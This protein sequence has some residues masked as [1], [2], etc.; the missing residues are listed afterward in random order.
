MSDIRCALRFM[1]VLLGSVL[2]AIPSAPLLSAQIAAAPSDPAQANSVTIDVNVADNLG[3]AVR[4]LTEQ[5]FTVLD[6][7][8]PAKVTG[9]RAVDTSKEPDAVR[10]LLVVDMINNNITSVAQER[11]EI[12]DF[13]KQDNGRLAHP[14]SLAV[15][16]ETGVKMSHSYGEDGNALADALAQVKTELRPVGAGAGFY[17]AAERVEDSLRM[18]TQLV[19]ELSKEPGRKLMIVI[20]PGWALLTNAGINETDGQRDWVFN[21]IVMLTNALR[22]AHVVL[23]SVNPFMLGRSDPFYYQSYRKPVTKVNNAEYPYLAQQVLAEHSGGLALTD[24]H[25]V[26]G[27]IN[28]AL[29]DA[30]AWYEVTLESTPGDKANEYH[31]LDVKVNQP[32]TQ[33]RTTAGYYARPQQLGKKTTPPSKAPE[34][35]PVAR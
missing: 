15:M 7:G 10:V 32:G 26:V 5:N 4:G 1:P 19:Q 21:A 8:Q 2:M 35:D 33:V 16:T 17:G 14:M 3:H 9:F 11:T 28:T 6:N 24:G 34:P 13:L 20:S 18:T 27:A 22:Q 31:K 23:Y 25:D 12:T 30:G 29:R